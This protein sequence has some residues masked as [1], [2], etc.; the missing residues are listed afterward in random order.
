MLVPLIADC[1]DYRAPNHFGSQLMD[2]VNFQ[3][4]RSGNV[5]VREFN[6]FK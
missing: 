2:A 3:S 4:Y 6:V 5:N 1:H